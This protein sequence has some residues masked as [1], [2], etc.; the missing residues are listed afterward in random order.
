MIDPLACVDLNAYCQTCAAM[1]NFLSGVDTK[2]SAGAQSFARMCA[3]R[4]TASLLDPK[5]HVI[6]ASNNWESTDASR[7][8]PAE[9][10]AGCA[11]TSAINNEAVAPRIQTSV[12][13]LDSA[14][15]SHTVYFRIDL[16]A[17]VNMASGVCTPF[18]Q[19]RILC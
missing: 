1:F 19:T 2:T 7:I 8:P 13:A 6:N 11:R 9:C 3:R 12:D 15:D 4:C 18:S 10:G 5:G 14:R 16:S 17:S